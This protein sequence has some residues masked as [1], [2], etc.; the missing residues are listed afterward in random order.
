MAHASTTFDYHYEGKVA[1]N[2]V[3]AGV[4]TKA[5]DYHYEG[6]PPIA[7]AAAAP[8]G[9]SIPIAMRHYLQM[10]GAG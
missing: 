2:E 4:D 10:Q 5:F 3:P 6:V 8:S 9:L 7:E 1:L